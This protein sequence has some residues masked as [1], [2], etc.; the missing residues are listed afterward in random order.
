MLTSDLALGDM[1]T[2]GTPLGDMFTGGTP[3]AHI[4]GDDTYVVGL[5]K[6][7][8][9]EDDVYKNRLQVQCILCK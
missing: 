3:L 5:S 9:D 2:G 7:Q 1:F 8:Q 4:A 6:M